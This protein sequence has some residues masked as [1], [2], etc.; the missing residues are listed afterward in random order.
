MTASVSASGRLPW[1][2]RSKS[3]ADRQTWVSFMA[4]L[5]GRKMARRDYERSPADLSEKTKRN[6]ENTKRRKHESNP[7]PS[8]V[9]SYFCAVVIEFLNPKTQP[10]LA[11]AG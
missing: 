9:F 8:F 7:P 6:H 10:N 2:S 4:A 3:A 11:L 5:H 1:R